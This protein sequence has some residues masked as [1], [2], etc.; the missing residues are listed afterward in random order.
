MTSDATSIIVPLV[1]A[2][3]FPDAVFLPDKSL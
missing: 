2:A 1:Q 3:S